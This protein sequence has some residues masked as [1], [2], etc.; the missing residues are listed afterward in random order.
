VSNAQSAERLDRK[1]RGW[2]PWVARAALWLAVLAT[3][4]Y[5]VAVL[6]WRYSGSNQWELVRE[7]DGVRLYTFKSPGFDVRQVRGVVT[8]EST[9]GGLVQFM[10][11]PDVCDQIGCYESRM[12]ENVDEQVQ[13]YTF[14][15]DYPF[16]FRPR[17][18]VV[19]AQFHQH[20]Q[21]GAVLLEF[22]AAPDKMPL[23][24]CC[25]RVTDMRNSWLFTPLGDGRVE[26]QYTMNMH[27]GGFIPHLLLNNVRPQVMAG[28]LPR[29]ES[30]I[31]RD[32]YQR[33]SFDFLVER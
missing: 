33:A 17:D 12:V 28:L 2:K 20:P 16:G 24:D 4:T 15:F 29:L 1:S 5:I 13:Y 19:R 3:V 21:T 14:R 18:F 25:V 8:V 10:K 30:M 26:V 31:A 27:E 23:N 32:E 9:L 7:Q 11:D 6:T 22:T